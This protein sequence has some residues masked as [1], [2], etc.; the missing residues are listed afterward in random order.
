MNFQQGYAQDTKFIEVDALTVADLLEDVQIDSD[1]VQLIKLDIEGAEVE[2]LSELL[3]SAIRPNQILVEFDEL[4]V[5]STRAFD[6]IDCLDSK[7]IENGYK[8]IY[9]DGQTN[10]L[11]IFKE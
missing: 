9:T 6:R 4:N 10:F 1:E 3:D 11:Y 8:C 2:V 7:L 5:P